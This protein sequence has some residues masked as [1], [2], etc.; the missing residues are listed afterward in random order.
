MSCM[1]LLCRAGIMGSAVADE[2]SL[3]NF[4]P[5]WLKGNNLIFPK[6][7]KEVDFCAAVDVT[8]CVC[9]SGVVGAATD[10]NNLLD[11]VSPWTEGTGL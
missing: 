4:L 2:Q 9:T 10:E 3:V 5:D 8:D 11:V 6:M 7:R 1:F